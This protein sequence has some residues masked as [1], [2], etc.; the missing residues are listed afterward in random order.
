MMHKERIWVDCKKQLKHERSY[1]KQIT[2]NIFILFE[3]ICL[4]LFSHILDTYCNRFSLNFYSNLLIS[5]FAF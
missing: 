5:S 4:M 1:E 2:D 3:V